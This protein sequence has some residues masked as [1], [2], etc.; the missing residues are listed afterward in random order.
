MKH[1][2]ERPAKMQRREEIMTAE[3]EA[4]VKWERW[5]KKRVFVREVAGKYAELLQQLLEQPRVYK[6]KLKPFKGGPTKFGKNIINPQEGAIAQAIETHID[7]L[8]PGQYGQKHGHMNSAVFYIMEGKGHE[9]HDGI[10]YEWE[11]GDAVIVGNARV[12]QH[13]NDDR[14][15]GARLLVIKAKPLFIFF[16]LL[17]QKTVTYPP[18]EPLPGFEDF[19]P[20]E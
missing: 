19:K 15:R 11:A 6:S 17:F 5:Q 14:T 13:F 1:D 18:S 20:P 8:A 16:N 7:V 12:H 4:E 10:R 9:V 3:K 2:G